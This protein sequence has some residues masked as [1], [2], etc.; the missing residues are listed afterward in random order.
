MY[1]VT[2][3]NSENTIFQRKFDSPFLMWKWI[4]KIKRS[5][6]LTFIGY[7]RC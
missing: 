7:V 3:R 5:K 4:N 6:E 2:V 1:Y